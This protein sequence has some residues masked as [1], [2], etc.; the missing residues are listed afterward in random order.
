[1]PSGPNANTR[2]RTV[3]L[4][5]FFIIVFSVGAYF[6]RDLGKLQDSLAVRE[7]QAALQ[8]VSDPSQIDEALRQ[9]PQNKFLQMM[10]MAARA[11]NETSVA[12]EKLSSELEPP[13]ISKAG[14]L[15]ALSRSDLEALRRD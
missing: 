14:N 5:L 13:A 10:A 2:V 11:A 6:A 15:A 3:F 4:F 7:S 1:M 9:Y 12:S 8:A